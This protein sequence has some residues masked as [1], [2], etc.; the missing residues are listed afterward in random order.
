M[1]ELIVQLSVADLR[2]IGLEGLA[3]C[4]RFDDAARLD[5][6]SCQDLT[7]SW[8]V[9][10]DTSLRTEDVVSSDCIEDAWRLREADGV[11]EF[12]VVIDRSETP[13][14]SA[15][16]ACDVI[17][18]GEIRPDDDLARFELV[19]PEET[20]KRISQEMAEAPF[21]CELV[22]IGEYSGRDGVSNRLTPRQEKLLRSA[23]DRGYYE[24]PRSADLGELA[25]RFDLDKSTVSEHLR[26]AERNILRMALSN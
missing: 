25:R 20:I 9:T 2:V 7:Q 17:C 24:V 23:Y 6:E 16:C 5:L 10:V 8:R 19:A 4:C 21:H 11:S 14:L 15:P 3:D 12:L 18:R 22:R 13:L 1:R 26:R